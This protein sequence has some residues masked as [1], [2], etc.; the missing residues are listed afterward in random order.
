MAF[1]KTPNLYDPA[2]HNAIESGQ[3]RLQP[4]QWIRCGADNDHAAMWVGINRESGTMYAAHWQGSA[5]RTRARYHALK[6][7]T[8]DRV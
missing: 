5:A 3:L 6:A 4:G 7:A 2:T 1:I 8:A